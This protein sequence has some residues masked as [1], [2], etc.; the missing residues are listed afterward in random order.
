MPLVSII[1]ACFNAENCIKKTLGSLIK[2]S[3]QNIEIILVDDASMVLLE[4]RLTPEFRKDD[5]IK[6]FRHEIN[7]GLSSARNTGLNNAKGDYV[8]FWD[9]DDYLNHDTV[10]KLLE[11]AI[12]N[13][14]QIVRGV[15]AR[16]DGSK[17]WV[18]KRGRS[19]LKNIAETSFKK[20]P[21]LTMDFTACGVLYLRSFL[22]NHNLVF[23]PGLY[24]QDIVFTTH[25][26]VYADNI[27]MSDYIV[28]DYFQSP[29]STSRLR[30]QKRF[31]SLFIVYEKL[32]ELCHTKKIPASQ[33]QGL[34]ASFI[35]AGVNTFLLWKLEAHQAE[36]DDLDRLSK[37]LAGVG[38]GAINQYCMD[39]L[40]EPSYLRLH[41]TRLGNYELAASTKN[42]SSISLEN[43]AALPNKNSTE[44]TSRA[45]VFLQNLRDKRENSLNNSRLLLRRDEDNSLYSFDQMKGFLVRMKSSLFS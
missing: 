22:E 45:T 1:V 44:K 20:S 39:M 18:T 13:S 32:E 28:G 23:E 36:I 35:N 37:L 16:T 15:L 26:L 6:I 7:Q 4:T 8:L 14:S 42:L 21:E 17:R 9:A 5:R 38:E 3:H 34:L 40:D 31:N 33:R 11:L 25:T 19:L 43:L 24:M 30:T 2:Q 12:R 41:A 29:N 10:K 27:C